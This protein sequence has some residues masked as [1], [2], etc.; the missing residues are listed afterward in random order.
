MDVFN[1]FLC[2]KPPIFE[3]NGKRSKDLSSHKFSEAEK[4]FLCKFSA[5]F[6]VSAEE[7]CK[8][9]SIKA[10]TFKSWKKG[11]DIPVNPLEIIMGDTMVQKN[12]QDKG[13]QTD[14]PVAETPAVVTRRK[15]FSS[16]NEKY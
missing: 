12:F 14:F 3:L 5:Y 6:R 13:V 8:L 11:L 16:M 9:F 1:D 15:S 4:A 7:L 10:D 2:S